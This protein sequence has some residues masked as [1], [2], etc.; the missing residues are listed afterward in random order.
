MWMRKPTPVTIRSITRV[1]G[2]RRKAKSARNVEVAIQGNG[3][4]STYGVVREPKL[5]AMFVTMVR[6]AAVNSRAMVVTRALGKRRPS[7]PFSRKPMNG[8][9]GINHRWREGVS[10]IV[11]SG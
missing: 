7:S 11:S 1:S 3:S 10:F 4:R 2:S 8:S 5:N 6:G 9:T